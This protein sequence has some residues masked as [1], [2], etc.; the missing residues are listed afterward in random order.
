MKNKHLRFFSS[1]LAF[2]IMA[3]AAAAVPVISGSDITVSAAAGD[4]VS[5]GNLCFRELENGSYGLYSC[6]IDKDTPQLIEIPDTC[7]NKPVTEISYNAF[8]S[9]AYPAGSSKTY[10]L[11]LGANIRTIEPY[12]L[13]GINIGSITVDPK[14]T[15]FKIVNGMLC[16]AD[17]KVLVYCPNTK[18]GKLNIPADVTTVNEG[19]ICSD[20]ITQLVVGK[21]MTDFPADILGECPNIQNFGVAEGNSS[22]S[23]LNG[24]LFNKERTVLYAYPKRRTGKYI[25]P[26]TVKTIKDNA[27]SGN[28]ELTEIDLK[29]T[30]EIGAGAFS[31]CTGLTSVTIPSS[32][33]IMGERVFEGCSSLASAVISEGLTEI[34]MSAF[35]GCSSLA[36]FSIPASVQKIGY[37]AFADTKWYNEQPDG[38][39]Y[40]DNRYLYCY[41]TSYI[42]S[43]G[44]GAADKP[45]KLVIKEGTQFVSPLALQYSNTVSI[46]IPKSLKQLEEDSFY[47]AYNVG[48]YTV[49]SANPS[50][51]VS[52]GILWSKDKSK[53]ISMPV[54]YKD[55]K[56]TV[57]KGVK[58]IGSYA[59]KFN[60]NVFDITITDEV[61]SFGKNPFYNGNEARAVVCFKA[62]PAEAAAEADHV[63]II[64]MTSGIKLNTTSVNIGVGETYNLKAAVTPD[65][66]DST[67]VWKSGNNSV[68]TVVNGKL[69]AKSAGT[70]TVSAANLKGDKVFCKVT[71]KNAP[72]SAA[73]SKSAVNI[74]LGE[75]LTL[76]STVN[77]GAASSVRKYTSSDESIVSIDKTKWNCCLTGKKKGTA[78]I[79]MT[80]YNGVTAKCRVTVKDAPKS[81]S[82]SKSWITI[83]LGE[84]ATIGSVTDSG[85]A[86]TGRVYTSANSKIAEITP[87]SWNCTFTGK[88]V[89]LTEI[90]VKLYNGLTAS[91]K[92]N[93]LAAPKAV[94]LPKKE[95]TMGVGE[96]MKLTSSLNSGEASAARIY[97]SSNAKY[98][99]M[100][101][102]DW[103]GEFK[104][105]NA[106]SAYVKVTTY[107]NVVDRCKII[108]KPAAASIK[109]SKKEL[110]L[111]VGQ[112]ASLSSVVNE[113]S[114]AANRTYSSGNSNIVKMTNTYWTG[115][116]K[117]VA[118]GTTYVKVRTQN[119]IEDTCKITVTK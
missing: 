79:T 82:M 66:A 101:R 18:K 64:Y 6:R 39:V 84:T 35:S 68:V 40:I 87:T 96:T 92:V 10:N 88:A 41:K 97:K 85:S 110:T 7:K 117:A 57:P 62:S 89:G 26:N 15:F 34:P 46:S 9:S 60:K 49:N 11:K 55:T 72:E 94:Y 32:V 5:S 99:R 63:E 51:T 1:I 2:S 37:R 38:F 30:E 116:F 71:V 80:T 78:E 36:D 98:V 23:V 103:V 42:S 52:D 44:S 22:F 86:A 77:D 19:A 61:K 16:S 76:G 59:F 93:V 56:Y 104:A 50:F 109:L 108:I 14:N 12:A 102:T 95:I 53:L 90:K 113:G 29:N 70:A 25:L 45:E 75:T 13:W 67:V 20:G 74:G 47:P 69:T 118:P 28:T 112:T 106:G 83:G 111:K 105:I 27:F 107:N 119:G 73:M 24:V 31:Y 114:A 54:K 81:V 65:T 100:T 8:D 91:C 115:S 58:A 3:G 17:G 21:S 48:S 4:R 43:D 33:K